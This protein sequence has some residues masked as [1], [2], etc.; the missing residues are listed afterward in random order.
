VGK[1]VQ[2]GQVDGAELIDHR[3]I[4]LVGT[5]PVKR[6]PGAGRRAP[7][8]GVHLAQNGVQARSAPGA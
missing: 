2:I 7:H 4:I 3:A 6:P 1:I 8:A 5:R